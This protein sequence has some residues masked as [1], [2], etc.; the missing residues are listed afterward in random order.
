VGRY[1][2]SLLIVVSLFSGLQPLGAD[3]QIR[4]L[5][6]QLRKRHLFFSN[7]D[8]EYTP[9]LT[10]AVKRY[11]IKK[12]FSPSGLADQETLASL[13]IVEPAPPGEGPP[14]VFVKSHQERRD[15]N[16]ALLPGSP[17]ELAANPSRPLDPKQVHDFV[18][19]YL[20]A[21]Q[22]RQL[23]DELSFYGLQ[24]DYFD[25]GTVERGYI[26]N[27]LAAYDQHWPLRRYTVG[28]SVRF[29]NR[30]GK[31]VAQCRIG[32]ELTN[33]RLAFSSTGRT[34]NSYVLRPREDG[35]WEIT[36]VKEEEVKQPAPRPRRARI[37]RRDRARTTNPIILA[38]HTV[39]RAMHNL[40]GEGLG[41]R[42]LVSSK[43]R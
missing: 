38:F 32:F 15:Q 26:Q 16:G 21:C 5:Q 42:K 37:L 22:S 10:T 19:R 39:D 6:E 14:T 8:G 18:R 30:D 33:E 35:E 11:Q 34:D 24:V 2:T 36:G 20:A 9:A 27:E 17:S 25:H 1:I 31:F 3:E 41:K 23:Q 29:I 7:I 43:R 12:G 40:F 13:G 4:Q 28:D